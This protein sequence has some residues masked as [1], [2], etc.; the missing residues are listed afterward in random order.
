MVGDYNARK[1][2]ER[3]LCAVLNCIDCTVKGKN[4][5]IDLDWSKQKIDEVDLCVFHKNWNQVL[6]DKWH[7][8]QKTNKIV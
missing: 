6:L 4:Y 2:F 7:A 8:W 1:T 3:K 5:H